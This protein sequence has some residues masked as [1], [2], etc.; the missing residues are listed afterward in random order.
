ME[1]ED[2]VGLGNAA[3]ASKQMSKSDDPLP[4]LRN[5]SNKF[6]S[7]DEI[8]PTKKRAAQN[9]GPMDKIYQKETR[10]EV[11]LTVAFHFYLNFISFN[12]ARSP[13]FIEMCRAL[14]E[15]APRGYVLPSSEKLKTTLFVKAKKEVAKILLPVKK[16]W[17]SSSVS[18][19]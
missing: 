1:K 8:Q 11:D 4:F 6:G 7:G 3:T 5:T 12:V 10:D 15:K 13:F 18:N 14:V 9:Y 19:G 17:I 2:A 16:S